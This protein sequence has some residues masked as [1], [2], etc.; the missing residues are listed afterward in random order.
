MI[1]VWQ[2][3]KYVSVPVVGIS[4]EQFDLMLQMMLIK[5][6][7]QK[8]FFFQVSSYSVSFDRNIST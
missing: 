7:Y 3:S 4:P 1:D 6:D 5:L 2:G 8:W